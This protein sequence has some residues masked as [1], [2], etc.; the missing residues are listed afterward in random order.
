MKSDQALVA[1]SWACWE[2]ILGEKKYEDP[3]A[4]TSVDILEQRTEEQAVNELHSKPL[5]WE[6]ASWILS[7]KLHN[8]TRIKHTKNCR[9]FQEL[10]PVLFSLSDRLGSSL[11]NYF[12]RSRCRSVVK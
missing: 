12:S 4:L 7:L 10:K 6:Q 9:L 1:A 11:F 3:S 5:A 8:L 2:I